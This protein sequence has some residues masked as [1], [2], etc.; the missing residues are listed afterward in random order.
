MYK[1][2]NKLIWF[3]SDWNYGSK[4][5]KKD[6]IFSSHLLLICS[7]ELLIITVLIRLNPIPHGG[8]GGQIQPS[9]RLSS[10]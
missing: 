9:F 2:S 1:N 4:L 8:G 5:L 7:R 3:A 6:N 10:L